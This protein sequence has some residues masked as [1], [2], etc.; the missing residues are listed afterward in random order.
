[1]LPYQDRRGLGRDTIEAETGAAT[2][3]AEAK[4]ARGNGDAPGRAC[5]ARAGKG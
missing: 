3:E 2:T 5:A 4:A 1:M